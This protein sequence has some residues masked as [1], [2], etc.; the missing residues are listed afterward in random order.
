MR[1]NERDTRV[2]RV[3]EENGWLMS[4]DVVSITKDHDASKSLF[5]LFHAGFLEREQAPG[6]RQYRYR[7]K[8]LA[9]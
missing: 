5:R 3:L 9:G 7:L 8:S 1:L 4:R 6:Y 2:L